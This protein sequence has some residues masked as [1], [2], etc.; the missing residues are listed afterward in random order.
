M[1]MMMTVAV[2]WMIATGGHRYQSC[3][4][5]GSIREF[6]SSTLVHVM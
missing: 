2:F 3:P 6:V 1:M 5:P 4:I